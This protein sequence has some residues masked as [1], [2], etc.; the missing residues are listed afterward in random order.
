MGLPS[1]GVVGRNRQAN[2]TP[3]SISPTRGEEDEVRGGVRVVGGEEELAV[4]FAAVKLTV[5]WPAQC[6]VPLEQVPI[7][8]ESNEVWA[9]VLQEGAEFPREAFH[10]GDLSHY[11]GAGG[12]TAGKGSAH[13]MGGGGCFADRLVL[14]Q[15]GLE[16]NSSVDG[17]SICDVLSGRY[18]VGDR[19]DYRGQTRQNRCVGKKSELG[20][21]IF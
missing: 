3:H 6:E 1:L 11:G 18:D 10:R 2:L 12:E 7:Q 5:L 14:I 13:E 9:G 20:F 19:G 15:V 4:V 16:V 17:S 8:G 21:W